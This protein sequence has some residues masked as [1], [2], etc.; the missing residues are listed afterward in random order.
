MKNRST[1]RIGF[2]TGL[3]LAFWSAGELNAQSRQVPA[4]RQSSPTAIVNTTLHNPPAERDGADERILESAWV[5]FE[6]GKVVEIG[7]GEP[8]LPE[9]CEI[10][11]GA[12]LH[13][14]PGLIA[15]PTELG[16]IETEQVRATDDT[17]SMPNI[18]RSRPGSP[19]TPTVS[20]F[21]SLE[22]RGS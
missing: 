7:T 3:A 13:V 15:G 20:S 10:L 2:W 16:L 4:A 18:P 17:S 8:E 22:A 11:D 5:L 12:G 9:G 21:P 19:S 14:Y 6:D 1:M